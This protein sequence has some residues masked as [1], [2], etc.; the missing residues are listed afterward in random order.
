MKAL[1][2]SRV[3]LLRLLFIGGCCRRVA[4]PRGA[5]ARRRDPRRPS[6]KRI[7]KAPPTLPP[8]FRN[9]CA[10]DCASGRPYCSDHCGFEYEFYYC[11]QQSFGCCKIGFGY[12]DGSGQLRCHP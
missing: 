1:G 4:L 6:L 3:L 7:G 2:I 12:C 8:R 11:S 9:H 5:R 10:I